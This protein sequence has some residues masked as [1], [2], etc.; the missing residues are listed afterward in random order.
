[1]GRCLL[2]AMGT[3]LGLSGCSVWSTDRHGAHATI[4]AIDQGV[5]PCRR[6][7]QRIRRAPSDRSRKIKRG[8]TFLRRRAGLRS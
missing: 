5:L 3:P 7:D 1:M 4:S 8:A 2:P 6:K